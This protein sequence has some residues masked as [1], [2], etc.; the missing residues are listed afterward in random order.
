[1]LRARRRGFIVSLFPPSTQLARQLGPET[2]GNCRIHAIRPTCIGHPNRARIIPHPI[3]LIPHPINRLLQHQILLLLLIQHLLHLQ[4]HLELLLERHDPFFVRFP[5]TNILVHL[6]LL[7]MERLLES[8]DRLGTLTELI[9]VLLRSRALFLVLSLET[10]VC[11]SCTL[12]RL[13]H[14]GNLGFKSGNLG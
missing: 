13:G 6:R 1:M 7:Q 14:F 11:R 8:L 10:G 3:H 2:L 12:Q 4:I 5:L 9:S